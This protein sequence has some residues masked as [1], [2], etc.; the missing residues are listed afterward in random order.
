MIVGARK[1]N[2]CLTET[3]FFN[4]LFM[5]VLT[6]ALLAFALLQINRFLQ[7]FSFIHNDSYID[8]VIKLSLFLSIWGMFGHEL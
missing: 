6:I 1:A 3:D 8:D 5:N 7:Q 2:K 4:F